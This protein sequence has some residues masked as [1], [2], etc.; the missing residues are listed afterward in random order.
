MLPP[1][2]FKDFQDLPSNRKF[3]ITNNGLIQLT[4]RYD[5]LAKPEG[6]MLPIEMQPFSKN[7][8]LVE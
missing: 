2:V 7:G 6:T 8:N 5:E 3:D 1:D 4:F